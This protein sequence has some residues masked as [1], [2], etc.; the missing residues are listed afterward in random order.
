LSTDQ[1]IADQTVTFTLNGSVG[2]SCTAMTSLN[3]I[4]ECNVVVRPL[5]LL[6]SIDSYTASY[7]GNASYKASS[8]T[9]TVHFSFF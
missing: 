4:A 8:A 7:G 1:G 6:L 2:E 3:G 5:T 9:V